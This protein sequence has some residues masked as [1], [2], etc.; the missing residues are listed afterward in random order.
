MIGLEK[1]T[2]LTRVY[3][4]THVNPQLRTH[5]LLE[6]TFIEGYPTDFAR[7]NYC[8]I[9]CKE[10]NYLFESKTREVTIELVLFLSAEYEQP[11]A[12]QILDVI[13]QTF[14]SEHKFSGELPIRSVSFQKFDKVADANIICVVELR[15]VLPLTQLDMF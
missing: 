12:S 10:V 9:D 6:F 13:A 15:C 7:A 11:E 14:A 2:E 1:I 8:Y 4:H 5:G 3:F